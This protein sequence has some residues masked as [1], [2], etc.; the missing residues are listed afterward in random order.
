MPGE[1]HEAV[2]QNR[3][4]GELAGFLAIDSPVSAMFHSGDK[5]VHSFS[6]RWEYV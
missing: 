5:P 3:P 1:F 4:D 2:K 6:G